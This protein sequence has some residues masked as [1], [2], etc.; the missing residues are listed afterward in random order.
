MGYNPNQ[1]KD[2][3]SRHEKNT[4]KPKTNNE[5]LTLSS[6]KDGQQQSRQPEVAPV[7]AEGSKQ[8]LHLY[9]ERQPAVEAEPFCSVGDG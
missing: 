8:H 9:D 4:R 5:K 3:Y 1:R 7:H 2:L 6:A